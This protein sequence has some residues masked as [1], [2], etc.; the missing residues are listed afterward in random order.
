MRKLCCI[1][2]TIYSSPSTIRAFAR[3]LWRQVQNW[4]NNHLQSRTGRHGVHDMSNKRVFLTQSA[5][6]AA[7]DGLT[8]AY[9]AAFALALG[10]SNEVIGFL[11]ALPWLA[12]ILTQIPGSELSQHF[13]RKKVYVLFGLIGRL[14]WIPLLAAPFFFEKPIFFI[15]IFYLIIKLGEMITDPAYTSLMAD[16]VPRDTFGDF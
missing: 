8:S 3:K 13:R 15:I 4:Q 10:A 16:V 9:L 14:F 5:L 1:H 2:Q 11:G 12:S 7:Y 6:W